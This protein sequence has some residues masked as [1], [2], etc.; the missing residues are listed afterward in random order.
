M[1]REDPSTTAPFDH[2]TLEGYVPSGTVDVSVGDVVTG[3]GPEVVRPGDG[4]VAGAV[5]VS[6]RFLRQPTFPPDT[7]ADLG[8]GGRL[9][10]AEVETVAVTPST[11]YIDTGED[12]VTEHPPTQGQSRVVPTGIGRTITV[13]QDD[14][15][16]VE[17]R[18]CEVPGGLRVPG[19]L[20]SVGV[21]PKEADN[22]RNDVTL[23]VAE[24]VG[25]P[26]VVRSHTQTLVTRV[27]LKVVAPGSKEGDNRLGVGD[28]KGTS[29]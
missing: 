10:R 4:P 15:V 24:E 21:G 12:G 19:V 7:T 27:H 28:T 22:R 2:E 9:I 23:V 18:Q 26:L 20:V 29:V 5:V 8:T 13:G 11:V 1:R 14:N 17:V 3:V 6:L 16:I 25:G